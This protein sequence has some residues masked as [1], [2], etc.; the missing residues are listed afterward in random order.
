MIRIVGTAAL[1]VLVSLPV[2]AGAPERVSGESAAW[3]EL[4]VRI[5]DYAGLSGGYLR[6][7]ADKARHVLQQLGI[8]TRWIQCRVSLD[9]LVKN[10][11][12]ETEPG[13]TVLQM[14]ILP[15]VMAERFG[16]SEGVFGFALP[17]AP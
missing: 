9:E 12:C 6:R 17:T 8:K 1:F 13:P 4:T 7:A 3:S 11:V 2:A 10:P 15:Q 14:K 5:Y 16:L